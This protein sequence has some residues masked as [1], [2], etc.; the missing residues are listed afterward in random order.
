MNKLLRQYLDNANTGKMPLDEGIFKNVFKM[1][2]RDFLS[3][4]IDTV[5][6]EMVATGIYFEE[7]KPFDIES[8]WNK[9][10]GSLLSAAADI[11]Y[12]QEN[13]QSEFNKL[14]EKFKQF[15]R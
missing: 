11:V 3:N 1:A 2:I 15:S 5:D 4:K 8:T 13:K 9:Q 7:N 6:L 10:F 14:I 12:M